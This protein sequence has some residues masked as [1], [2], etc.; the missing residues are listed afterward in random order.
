LTYL[1]RARMKDGSYAF[2]ANRR[3]SDL[4][5]RKLEA[6]DFYVPNDIGPFLHVDIPIGKRII[7]RER[8]RT[9]SGGRLLIVALENEDRSEVEVWLARVNGLGLEFAHLDAYPD[10]APVLFDFEKVRS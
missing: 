9:D 1:W 5:R 7:R 2:S 3:W 6:V 10:Y 4:D 8:V